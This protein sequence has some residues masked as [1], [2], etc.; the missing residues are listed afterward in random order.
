M[1]DNMSLNL[2][3]LHL[4]LALILLPLLSVTLFIEAIK[5]ETKSRKACVI[6]G[7]IALAISAF[8]ILLPLREI[9]I[10]SAENLGILEYFA[11]FIFSIPALIS[12]IPQ[13]LMLVACYIWFR[14]TKQKKWIPIVTTAIIVPLS[15]V[16]WGLVVNADSLLP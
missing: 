13:A 9:D 3:I 10:A 5:K 1:I 11:L 16:I 12:G 14:K 6:S 8:L 15:V 7:V 4:L 2:E